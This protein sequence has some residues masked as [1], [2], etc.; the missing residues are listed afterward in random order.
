MKIWGFQAFLL[1]EKPLLIMRV[2]VQAVHLC[3]TAAYYVCGEV[4]GRCRDAYAF[5]A[6]FCR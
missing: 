4:T 2:R 1:S 5:A 6:V 3:G